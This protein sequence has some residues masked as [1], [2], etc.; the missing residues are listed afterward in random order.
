MGLLSLLNVREALWQYGAT[1]VPLVSATTA[2]KSAFDLRVNQVVERFLEE[3]KPRNTLRRV[4]VPIIN[5]MITLPR[6]LETVLGMKLVNENNCACG[7]LLIYSR[8]HEFAHPGAPGC[9]SNPGVYPLSETVQV[10]Q[11]PTPYFKLRITSTVTSGTVTFIGG[12][13]T[14][15]DEYFDSVSLNITNGTTT[16]TREWATMPQI[17]KSATTVGVEMYSVDTVSSDATLVAVYAPG[18]TIPAY[19]RYK[20]PNYD[21]YNMALVHGKLAYVPVTGDTEIVYPGKLG[22]L[23]LGL[24][25][26]NYEDKNDFDRAD[27]YWSRALSALDNDRQELDGDASIPVFRVNPGFMAGDIP[28]VI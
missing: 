5:G 25:A 28:N 22:A 6:N 2:Q 16:T 9:C 11:D 7:P 15:G 1:N 10:F 23:K 21:G 24:M 12:R 19:R 26:L 3:M 4:N 14:D 18:E 20:V 13:D 27:G 17:Q 8:F